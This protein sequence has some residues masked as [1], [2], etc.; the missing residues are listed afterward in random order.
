M[1]FMEHVVNLTSR[2]R[3]LNKL[4]VLQEIINDVKRCKKQ[5]GSDAGK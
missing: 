2:I 3:T 4:I 5:Q 1:Y